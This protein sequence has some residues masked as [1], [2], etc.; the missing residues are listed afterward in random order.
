MKYTKILIV[1]F[2]SGLVLAACTTAKN[3]EKYSMGDPTSTGCS[4]PEAGKIGTC[5]VDGATA[6]AA[7][8]TQAVVGPLPDPSVSDLTKS[9]AQGSV[10]V[11]ITPESLTEPGD[12][13]IFDVSMSTHS[14]DLSMDLAQLSILTTDT[15]ITVQAT[16]W[17]AP[18]GGHHVEGKL[19]FPTS[20]DG[21]NI[22]DGAN[23]ITITINN[24]DAPTRTFIWQLMN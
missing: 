17:D 4:T 23:S 11:E 18:S 21:K 8:P 19:S 12:T 13:L 3:S 5:T 6:T 22:L 14:V 7:V 9:D 2:L 10:T 24:V 20:K 1:I 16:Q 15:G